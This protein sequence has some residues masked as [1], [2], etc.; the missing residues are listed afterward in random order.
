MKYI[1]E[2]LTPRKATAKCLAVGLTFLLASCGA[3]SGKSNQ[4][5]S[6][7]GSLSFN[8]KWLV[9]SPASGGAKYSTSRAASI[10]CATLGVGTVIAGV[11]NSAGK[12]VA[13][14]GPW[15]CLDGA[16]DILA[17]TGNGL[18]LVIQGQTSTGVVTYSGSAASIN[19]T[20]GQTSDLG[21]INIAA[22]S[23][24]PPLSA[25]SVN[26]TIDS[27]GY[28]PVPS[29]PTG[30]AAVAGNGLVI[31]NWQSVNG[32]TSYNIYYSQT[33]GVTTANGNRVALAVSGSA[34]SGLTNGTKYYF[35]VTAVNSAGES[36]VSTE[37]NS[38]P[39]APSSS[40]GASVPPS[41][42]TGVSAS[43]GNGSVSVSWTAVTGAISYN[44]YY[45]KAAGVTTATGTKISGVASGVTITGL[46]NGT[47]YYF[48]VTSIGLGG[49]SALSS[50]VNAT[51]A[52]LTTPPPATPTG[53]SVTGGNGQATI[54]WTAVT[55]A[56]SYNVYYRAS[57]GVTTLNG[58]KQVNVASGGVITG[59]TNGT[60][61]YFIVTA[62]GA[63]GEGV[64]S[65]AAN[66]TLAGNTPSAPTG[67]SATAGNGQVTPIWTSVTGATS[68]N[69]YYRTTAGVTI[70]TG[71]KVT[72]A[73]SG[74]AISSLTNG[75]TYYFVV[76]AVNAGGESTISSEV[77]AYLPLKVP[78]F[79][80]VANY[81]SN[82][83]SVY[84]I[85]Q[86]TGALTTG[87]AVAA[88]TQPY[89]VAVD[90]TGKFAY[91]ANGGSHNVSVYTINQT[92]GAL[93]AGTAVAAGTQPQSVT[94][95]PSGKFAYVANRNSNNVSVYT[96]DQTTG[97][98]TAGTAV[99][100][101]TSPTSVTV[102]PSGKFAYAA[103]YGSNN[104]SVYTIN[105]TTGA[106]TA[107]TA[108]AAGT[109]PWS[110]ITSGSIQ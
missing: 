59:L 96:I 70:A 95:D 35:A 86:T 90:P 92:T 1:F 36:A 27:Y 49:E 66:V 97:A 89:L 72:G 76:T 20:A 46:A 102:D 109:N 11:S 5:S 69:V 98:L 77:A 91:V 64:A 34:V 31:L 103:N 80:Y 63:G 21:T 74:S 79:A 23:G 65:A 75:T 88:G 10:D 62:V 50:E 81:N 52:V 84:T 73:S 45:G 61:Y 37:V 48:V 18:K 42:P 71:T 106:L 93:T 3:L 43:G 26:Q 85:N 83:V 53:I 100:A 15:S 68:Y 4:G 101:G 105:A 55:G 9:D 8:A 29:A 28:V 13:I 30:L 24:I 25:T 82:D 51:P 7:T 39:A 32:A 67:V 78:R 99:A 33:S 57:S 58:T 6:S 56:T 107:G 104:V 38:T 2:G 87:T 94:V 16:G 110:V 54:S 22:A 14:G 40:G 17:P 12:I 47:A 60:T 108:V 41:I 44:I 19:V